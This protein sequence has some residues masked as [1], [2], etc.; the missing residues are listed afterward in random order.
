MIFLMISEKAKKL[1]FSRVFKPN[2]QSL[3]NSLSEAV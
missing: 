2:I 1:S 3:K